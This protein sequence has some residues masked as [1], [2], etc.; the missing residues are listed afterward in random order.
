M[1]DNNLSLR[2]AVEQLVRHERTIRTNLDNVD[3]EA[4]YSDAQAYLQNGDT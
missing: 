2:A 3:F 1:S 4:Q